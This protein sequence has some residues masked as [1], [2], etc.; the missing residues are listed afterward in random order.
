VVGQAQVG[1]ADDLDVKRL[2]GRGYG[3]RP[4]A[5]RNGP[6]MLA[7][8]REIDAQID[9]DPS[10]PLAISQPLRKGLGFAQAVEEA[11]VFGERQ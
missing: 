9:G 2:T 6:V 10:E 5:S 11:R 8:D 3:E 7:H 1:L 4:L